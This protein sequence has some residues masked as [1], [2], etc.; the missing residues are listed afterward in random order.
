MN[1]KIMNDIIDEAS[2]LIHSAYITSIIEGIGGLIILCVIIYAIASPSK[3]PEITTLQQNFINLGSVVG[4]TL[5]EI[6]SSLEQKAN[7]IYE[8][9]GKKI[10]TWKA[11]E[12][13]NSYSI[14]LRFDKSN[15]CE[16]ITSEIVS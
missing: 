6:E 10:A 7:S 13:P 9:N 16:C 3:T 2:Y 8:I 14:E 11:Y 15:K 4:K 1:S 5:K 12:S